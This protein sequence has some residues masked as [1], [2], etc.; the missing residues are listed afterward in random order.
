MPR[1]IN[2]LITL[3]TARMIGNDLLAEQDLD[4]I[5][6]NAHQHAASRRLGVDAVF[7]LVMGDQACRRCPCRLLDEAGERPEEW[8]EARTLFLENLVDRPVLELR[9]PRPFGVGNA[10]P[11]EP[12]VQLGERLH[13]RL[14][15]EQNITQRANLV[16]DLAF[17]PT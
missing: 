14:W 6:E 3:E 2:D 7:N 9:V 10:L 5:G 12:G 15:P 8:H 11:F 4:A 16:L 1:V 13:L 17:L